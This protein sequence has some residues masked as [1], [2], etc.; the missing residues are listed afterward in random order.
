[1]D[2]RPRRQISRSKAMSTVTPPPF[3]HGVRR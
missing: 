2:V 1:M 3:F